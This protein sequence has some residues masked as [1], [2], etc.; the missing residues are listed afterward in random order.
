[1]KNSENMSRDPKSANKTGAKTSTSR[2]RSTDSKPA[3][4]NRSSEKK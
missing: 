2:S 4:K 3:T 1:M